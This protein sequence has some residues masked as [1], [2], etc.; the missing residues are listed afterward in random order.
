MAL[1]GLV[2]T[3]V[4]WLIA[5]A[6]IGMTSSTGGRLLLV[7]IGIAV[8]LIGS[9]RVVNQAYQKNAVWKR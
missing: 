3:L 8:S 2:I 4:G 7:L 5:V 6:S 9:L 1:V